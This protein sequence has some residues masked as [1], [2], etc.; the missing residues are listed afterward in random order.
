MNNAVFGKSMENMRKHRDK[1]K[2]LFGVRT[3]FSYYKVS[4]RKF[5][6]NRNE[7]KTEKLMNKLIY[8]E[9][10]ILELSKILMY[11]FWYDYVKPSYGENAKLWCSFMVHAKTDDIYKDIAKDTETRF[12]T[13]NL[14]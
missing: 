9:L 6:S 8:L 1:K 12:D 13:P 3:K 5:I 4:H 10:S 7:K 14:S 2:K 11:N